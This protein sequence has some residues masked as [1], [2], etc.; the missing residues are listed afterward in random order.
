[1][2]GCCF[3]K[4][5]LNEINK[6]MTKLVRGSLIYWS[7]SVFFLQRRPQ[8]NQRTVA[9]LSLLRYYG[10]KFIL[11]PPV[12]ALWHLVRRKFENYNMQESDCLRA[13]NHVSD[14]PCKH[15][16]G[17][18]NIGLAQ[19]PDQ[20]TAIGLYTRMTFSIFYS[21]LGGCDRQYVFYYT[22]LVT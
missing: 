20:R 12:R 4:V 16:S 17:R 11:P 22:S 8:A 7:R 21:H 2:P 14:H 10:F 13:P 3:S 1:M 6:Y 9:I 15:L 18:F 19:D 5:K